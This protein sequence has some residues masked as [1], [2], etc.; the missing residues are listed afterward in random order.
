VNSRGRHLPVT[1]EL[2]GLPMQFLSTSRIRDT[3]HETFLSGTVA[4]PF[5]GLLPGTTINGANI[6]RAQLLR[7]FPQYLAGAVNGAV[8]GTGTISVGTEEYVGS[9]YFQAGSIR[10]E[11]RF[12]GGHSLLTTYTRSRLEDKLNYLNPSEGVL[13]ERISPNDRPHRFTFGGT[14]DLPFGRGR[15]FGGD[16]KGLMDAALGGWSLSATYQYQSGFPLTWNTNIYYD[17]ERDPRDLKSNI[18]GDCPGGGRAGLDCPAWDTSGFYIAGGT[19][20]TDPRIVL[21]NNVRYF[22]STLPNVR[23]DDLHL[24]DIGIYKTFFL[25]MDMELQLRIE[26]INALNYTVLWN[27]NQD[28]RSASFGLVNQDR[29]NPRDVQIGGKLT[30]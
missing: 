11:K 19:G 5:Q 18:G 3:A 24:M 20:R 28:P 12:S 2:N 17:P 26:T 1:R 9:D 8:S 4:N 22:P 27:P 13:E 29:N 21:G 23:T 6:T 7:A 14:Y 10:V 30:F 16:W 25:P 15:R